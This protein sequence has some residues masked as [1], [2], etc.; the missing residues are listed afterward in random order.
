MRRPYIHVHTLYMYMYAYDRPEVLWHH[1][2]AVRSLFFSFL[3]R[4]T[5]VKD[6]AVTIFK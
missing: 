1:I 3:Y 4:L 5:A 2:N 6:R